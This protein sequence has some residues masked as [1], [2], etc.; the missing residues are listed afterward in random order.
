MAPQLSSL[1]RSGR[2][3][4]TATAAA[5]ATA[6]A[7]VAACGGGSADEPAAS[8]GTT[9]VRFGFNWVDDVEWAGYYLA[10]QK[11]YFA[12][13]GVKAELVPG[14][15][16][17]PAVTQLIAA[18]KV[19]MGVSSDE[20]QIINANK[21]GGDY[22]V[23]AATYAKSP[24][25]LTW[26]AKTPINSPADLKGKKIGGHQGEQPRLDAVFTA[27]GMKPDY[28]FVPMSY[29][30]QPL[31]KGDMDVITSYSTN[32]PIS[33]G[34]EGVQTKAV[35]FSDFGLPS[36]GDLIFAS[37]SYLDSHQEAVSGF[38]KALLQGIDD[39][40]AD[41]AAGVSATVKGA[42]PDAKIDE[43]YATAANP[44][45]I[46]LLAPEADR[47]AVDPTFMQDKVFKG[48]EAAGEKDLPPVSEFVDM[49]FLQAAKA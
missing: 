15:E 42:G 25:G 16:N 17:T 26:L 30:P 3:R 35:T 41:P 34:Q 1:S 13:N 45:Y 27:N 33:L 5:L 28:T 48:Y 43:K 29:D 24:Y 38:L 32:Q 20:L 7:L 22:V 31:V 19:D 47:L 37:R 46:E 49:S 23:I 21:E 8:G 9:T 12:A 6:V 11:G 36:Y 4:R 2:L 10:D 18:G 39:N 14:G 44:A 40:V